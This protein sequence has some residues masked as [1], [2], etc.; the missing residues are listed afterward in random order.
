MAS[1]PSATK[2]LSKDEALKEESRFL[3]GTILES[4][5][6]PLTGDLP[7]VDAKLTKFH[8]TYLQDNRDERNER[9]KKRLDKAYGFMVRVRVPGGVCT[10]AQWLEMDR[11]ADAYAHGAL[12]LT[13]R[14]AFQFHGVLKFNLK[15]TIR[16]INEALLSTIAACG[17]VNRNVM[18]NPNPYESAVHAEA[19]AITQALSDHFIPNTRA[20]HEIWLD[21]EKLGE[22]EEDV[23][24]IYGKTYLPRKFK[25]VVAVPP[26]NDVDVYAHDLGF[27]AI[28]KEGRI[29]GYNVTVGGGMGMTHGNAATRPRLADV[30]AFCKPEDVIA[31]A[32]Q[33]VTTQRDYGDRTNRAHARL[34]YTIEDRGIDWFREEVERRLGKKLEDPK[35]FHFDH[36]GDRYGWVEGIDGNWHLTLFIEN[37]RVVDEGNYPLK[38]GLREIARVH[39]G[40]FRLTGNQNLIIG[41]VSPEEKDRIQ[42]LAEE[43]GLLRGLSGSGVR[44]NSMACVALPTCGLALAESQRYLP[45]LVTELETE[46][47]RIGLEEDEIVVRMT[48]C[49]NGCAR[50]FLAEIAFVGKAPDK[51]NVYLGAAFDGSRLGSL[52]RESVPGPQLVPLLMPLLKRYRDER[53]EGEHFGDFCLRAGIVTPYE[54]GTNYHEVMAAE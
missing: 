16:E 53:E 13:T 39:K 26:S 4:L 45:S 37:G 41:R 12:K 6:D 1:E 44:R 40:D 38:A 21:G 11:L 10:P 19:Q 46:M 47:K 22:G 8:G 50:P 54:A 36:N 24:P 34:K 28:L 48:G 25:I 20:Y 5:A 3:R 18:C 27:I 35:P 30:M 29:V 32:E 49:P 43:F 42:A 2:P 9:R 15:R 7:A 14:Q 52:Y 33:V 23:E 51:Y 31:V 17:D